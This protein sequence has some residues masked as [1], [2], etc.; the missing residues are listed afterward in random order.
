MYVEAIIFA[1]TEHSQKNHLR[2]SSIRLGQQRSQKLTL[3]AVLEL[4]N[5]VVLCFEEVR[6]QRLNY[7]SFGVLHIYHLQNLDSITLCNLQEACRGFDRFEISF[8][9]IDDAQ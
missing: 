3:Q 2:K 4:D 6:K 8:E 1:L 9:R 5:L 7:S